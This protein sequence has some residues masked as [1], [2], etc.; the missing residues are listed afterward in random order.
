MPSHTSSDSPETDDHYRNLIEESVD[1]IGIVAW[2]GAF[3]TVNQAFCDIFGYRMDEIHGLNVIDNYVNHADR[4]KLLEE[5]GREGSV[6]DFQTRMYQKDRRIIW[7]QYSC[8][9]QTASNNTKFNQVILRDITE[10]KR[11][12]A[13]AEVV[14]ELTTSMD[15]E[16]VSKKITDNV[17]SLI[18]V[19]TAFVSRLD[20]ISGSTSLVSISGESSEFTGKLRSYFA[21]RKDSTSQNGL[22]PLAIRERRPVSTAN[23]ST[24]ARFTYT[25]AER[26]LLEQLDLGAFLTLPFIVQDRLIGVLTL[27]DQVGREFTDEEINLAQSFANHAAMALENARLLEDTEREKERSEAL[28][29]VSNQLAGVHETDEIL[30]L[31]VNEATRLLSA[32][33][34]FIRL[35]QG[36]VLVASAATESA[37]DFLADSVETLLNLAV[38]EHSSAMGQVMATKQPMVSEDRQTDELMTPAGRLIVQ[39]HG[40][41]GS[42][43]VPLLANGRS[44]GVLSLMDTRIRR[45]TDD[46]VSLLMAFADQASLALEKARLLGEGKREKD[47][48]DALYQVSNRL[49]GAHETGEILGLIV[50]EATRILGATG[51]WIRLLEGEVML[52]SSTRFSKS[53]KGK[54]QLVT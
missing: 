52:L 30:E 28:Y 29:Q 3:I 53:E 47:R 20:P 42:A 7:V 41:H 31:V 39:K 6:R 38:E 19:R 18:G 16:A 36:D 49:A 32:T 27:G 22:S 13:L 25:K 17:W 40:Y 51:A 9:S 33:S 12:D 46:E 48:S 44:I 4:E 21:E 54:V 1:P 45:F 8:T 26:A 37:A 14:N 43:M 2:D 15:Y 11:A 23:A 24:D 35:L 34:A 50:N 10:L 5:L